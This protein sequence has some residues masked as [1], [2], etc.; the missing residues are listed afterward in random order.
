MEYILAMNRFTKKNY[1]LFKEFDVEH[2]NNS[3]RLILQLSNI[4]STINESQF[5]SN[6]AKNIYYLT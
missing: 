4:F 6:V 1:E 3:R 2:I 5:V